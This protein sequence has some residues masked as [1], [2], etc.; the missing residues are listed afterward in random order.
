MLE[1]ADV[2]LVLGEDVEVFVETICSKKEVCFEAVELEHAEISSVHHVV[3]S[4][5]H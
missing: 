5:V 1:V 3:P 4:N 2:L